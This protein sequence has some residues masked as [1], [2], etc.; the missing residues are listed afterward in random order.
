MRQLAGWLLAFLHR[1]FSELP[2]RQLA[3]NDRP[4]A[5]SPISE[6]PM[7]QLA[8][9]CHCDHAPRISELPMRQLA[10]IAEAG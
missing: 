10:R 1:W 4:S 3:R 8:R 2:M 9:T 7:R 5:S 6:L